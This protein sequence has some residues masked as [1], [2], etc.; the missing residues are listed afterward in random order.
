MA[1]VNTKEPKAI[2]ISFWKF[3]TI[4]G[5]L[6]VTPWIS[7]GFL[8]TFGIRSTIGFFISYTYT[9]LNKAS[10]YTFYHL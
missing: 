10:G 7:F 5:P 2:I 8:D 1:S 3:G 6:S 9:V 4:M